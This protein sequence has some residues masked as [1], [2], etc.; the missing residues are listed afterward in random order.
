MYLRAKNKAGLF[1]PWRYVRSKLAEHWRITPPQVDEL[2]ASE[3]ALQV[4]LWELEAAA[5]Q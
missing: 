5:G 3:I 2:P 4:E 1:L